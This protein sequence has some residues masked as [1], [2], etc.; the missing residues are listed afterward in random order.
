[1][2]IVIGI[3]VVFAALIIFGKI[4]GAPEPSSM[5]M[6]ALLGRMQSEGRWIEKY[7]ALPYENQQG[8][9]LKKQYE[10]KQ[11]YALELH[12][13][14]MKRGLVESGKKLEETMIPIMLRSIELMKSGMSEDAA[15]KQATNEFVKKRDAGLANKSEETA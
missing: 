10:G 11:L 2:E 9:G 5:S 3:I 14:F 13:E 6:E 1:M 4:K 15:G 7:K 8:A 12:V